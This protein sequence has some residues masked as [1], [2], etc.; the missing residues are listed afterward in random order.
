[1]KKYIKKYLTKEWLFSNGFKYN[2]FFSTDKEAIYSQRFVIIRYFGIPMIECEILIYYPDG[3]VKINVYKA[4]TRE[5]HHAFYNRD[6]G[7]NKMRKTIDSKIAGIL[8]KLCIDE[9][10]D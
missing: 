8:K 10:T 2:R 3:N 6:Y 7:R 4:G 5:K 9:V 1:M